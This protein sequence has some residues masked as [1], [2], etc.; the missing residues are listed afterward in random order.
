M[1]YG[2]YY[3]LTLHIYIG[4]YYDFRFAR[5]LFYRLSNQ[6][7]NYLLS[8]YNYIYSKLIY[9]ISKKMIIYQI[10]YHLFWLYLM[11]CKY[12]SMKLPCIT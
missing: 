10:N 2:I 5:F 8:L 7:E 3:I 4:I 11:F 12:F 6:I 1:P 9:Q